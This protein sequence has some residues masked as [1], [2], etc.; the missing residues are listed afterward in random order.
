MINSEVAGQWG[1]VLQPPGSQQT[2]RCIMRE[3]G[4]LFRISTVPAPIFRLVISTLIHLYV[5]LFISSFIQ[6]CVSKHSDL[7]HPSKM[8]QILPTFR[9]LPCP[10]QNRSF[11]CASH[12]FRHILLCHVLA[13]SL[14]S[15][16]FCNQNPCPKH[17]CIPTA[18]VQCQVNNRCLGN[19]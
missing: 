5:C 13:L 11:I 9:R 18:L 19:N 16:P 1:L 14:V 6:Q 15:L 17:L 2:Q 10:S 7:S 12:L 4:D 3:S 8:T